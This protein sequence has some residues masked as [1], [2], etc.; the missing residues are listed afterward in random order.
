MKVWIINI[1]LIAFSWFGN[2]HATPTLYKDAFT[3]AEVI[4][5]D[6]SVESKYHNTWIYDKVDPIQLDDLSYV[7]IVT[8]GFY[9]HIQYD[10]Q[11]QLIESLDPERASE[12][13]FE[14]AQRFNYFY[15]QMRWSDE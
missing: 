9:L 10:G 2:A 6:I 13:L 7:Y 5:H 8:D 12:E 15:K 14:T 11:V 3:A 4:W 1:I